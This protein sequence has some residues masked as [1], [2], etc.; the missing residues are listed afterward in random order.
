MSDAF[1]KAEMALFAAQAM[2]VD[3]IVTTALIPGK[4]A[5]KLI[6]KGMLES[7]KAGS[8]I[9]DLAGEEGG[10][11][12]LTVPGEVSKYKAVAIIAYPDLPSR[13]ATMARQLYGST[14]VA[15]LDEL[16]KD[17]EINVN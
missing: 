8:V 11:C 3:I 1:L 16:K 5:P 7:M 4:P 10:D 6:T 14:I 12:A 17:D 9:V 2:E 15:L 13:M